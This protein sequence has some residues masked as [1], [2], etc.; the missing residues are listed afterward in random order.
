[1]DFVISLSIL[2][3]GSVII[4]SLGEISFLVGACPYGINWIENMG[5]SGLTGR[6]DRTGQVE[7]RAGGS[8]RAG[9]IL[10]VP[11]LSL[12]KRQTAVSVVCHKF[13]RCYRGRGAFVLV[14]QSNHNMLH[15]NSN[16]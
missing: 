12:D 7:V 6:R 5:W 15:K 8:E 13:N 4:V 16:C 2:M 9:E 14:Q 3:C 1:M 10:G 11:P